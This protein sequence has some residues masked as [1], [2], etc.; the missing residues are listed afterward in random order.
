MPK[1]QRE[2]R[3]E[4]EEN[5]LIFGP[6]PLATTNYP[7]TVIQQKTPPNSNSRTT[8]PLQ[9]RQTLIVTTLITSLPKRPSP[10]ANCRLSGTK[11]Q[12]IDLAQEYCLSHVEL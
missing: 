8:S 1:K 4:D 9:I 10:G 7:A 6:F 2:E 12:L 5:E 11:L 3:S